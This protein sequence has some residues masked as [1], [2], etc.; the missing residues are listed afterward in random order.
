MAKRC[1]S[2]SDA[3]FADEVDVAAEGNEKSGLAGLSLRMISEC[4]ELLDRHCASSTHTLFVCLGAVDGRLLSIAGKP[5]RAAAQRIAAVSSSLLALGES[6]A[7]EALKS[8]ADYGVVS[9]RHGSIVTVRIPSE[10]AHYAL[11]LAADK[12]E[13][14]ALALRNALDLSHAL[15][16]IL[17]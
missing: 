4:Q 11:S 5:D 7:R 13:T 10:S 15:G 16:K 6:F 12:T 9:A 3:F 8:S 17:P 1:R 14:V 2:R